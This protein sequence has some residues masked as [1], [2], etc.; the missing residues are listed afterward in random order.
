VEIAIAQAECRLV[1]EQQGNWA[2]GRPTAIFKAWILDGFPK[3]A[4][5]V[6]GAR[7]FGA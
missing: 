1:G 6:G 5:V 2:R 4:V 7:G 3:T